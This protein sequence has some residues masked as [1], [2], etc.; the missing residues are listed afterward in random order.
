MNTW[1]ASLL[2]QNGENTIL[3][4]NVKRLAEPLME[5]LRDELENSL[6]EMGKLDCVYQDNEGVLVHIL[7]RV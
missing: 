6:L 3:N 2:K 7:K 4:S 5:E 1:S